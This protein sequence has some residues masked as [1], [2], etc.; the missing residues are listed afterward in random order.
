MYIT[1]P[2]GWT[3]WET[4]VKIAVK[5]MSAVEIDIREGAGS[6]FQRMPPGDFKVL[7]H[8]RLLPRHPQSHRSGWNPYSL[9]E[10]GNRRVKK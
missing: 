5:D 3:E 4:E 10:T 7:L 9:R 2:T 1:I 6:C 8:T